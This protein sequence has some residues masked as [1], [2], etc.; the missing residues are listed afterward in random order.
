MKKSVGEKI[1]LCV[2]ITVICLSVPG[3]FLFG[4]LLDNSNEENREW[5]ER[6]VLTAETYDVFAAD[7]TSYFNDRLPFRNALISINSG[8]DYFLF[9]RSTNPQVI[10]GNDGWL[11]YDRS[12]DGDPMSGYRGDDLFSEEEL[13]RIAQNCMEQR[14]HLKQEGK[15]FVLFIVPGK[16]RVYA[17]HMPRWMGGPAEE[18]GALQV[19]KYLKK[20]TDI[21]IVYPYQDMTDAK[22]ETDAALYYK[23]DTHWT[24]VGAYAGC[25]SLLKER[26]IEMPLLREL[27][28][29]E[30]GSFSG[31]LAGMLNLKKLLSDTDSTY[32][33]DGYDTHQATR[34]KNSYKESYIYH[35]ENADRR[36]A[37]VIRDSFGTNMAPI[38]G[39]Q[40]NDTVLRHKN[41]YSYDDLLEQDPDIVILE[42]AD[43][44]IDRLADFSIRQ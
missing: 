44:Y 37:Y 3:W 41:T 34:I 4:H 17:E 35:A 38:I 29:E 15:E 24:S 20:N 39:S 14:D 21:I 36:K 26:G 30:N 11:F 32:A 12:D 19:Y 18:Y 42:T 1:L 28:I 25:R 8:I 6:P 31:D 7:F 40:F 2:F 10:V 22:Q 43:R 5:A 9:R 27:R 13:H 33:I 16:E 23:T